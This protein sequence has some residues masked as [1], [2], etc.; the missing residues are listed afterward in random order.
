MWELD[1]KESWALK[2]WCF[3]TVVSEKTLESLLDCE[4][5]KPVLIS[6]RNKSWI[7]IGRTDAEAETPILCPPD[8]K[9]GL[10]GKDPDAE[11]YWR[12]EEKGTKEDETV[13]LYHRLDGHEFEQAL[14]VGEGQGSLACNSSWCGNGHE[15]V[16]HEWATELNWTGYWSFC[17]HPLQISLAWSFKKKKRT[18]TN[19]NKKITYNRLQ[20]LKINKYMTIEALI[21]SKLTAQ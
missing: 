9:N 18:I 17:S 15:W 21:P 12:W 4:E 10:F 5:I 20:N 11:K 3:W 6:K 16:G 7:F 1:Y 2:N 19:N 13:R 8:V 14:G